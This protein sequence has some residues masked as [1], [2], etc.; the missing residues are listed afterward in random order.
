MAR[1]A[2]NPAT[3]TGQLDQ[4]LARSAIEKLKRR[5]TPTTQ[6]QRAL[7][8]LESEREE[9]LR[10]QYYATIPQKHWRQMSGR[11][12]KVINE[13]AQL[14]GIPF[15]GAVVNLPDVVRTLHDLLADKG[16][17][18]L[19]KDDDML[20]GESNSPAL[21]RYREEKA[22][23]ARLDRLEREQQLIRR[24]VVREGTG[25]IAARLRTAGET[26]ER[27]YG[28]GALEILLEALADVERD[29]E[30]SYSNGSNGHLDVQRSG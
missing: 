22:L 15:G 29:I 3:A 10:W 21:E 28:R 20:L 8:R 6:E 27:Q 17:R 26:L 23:L 1:N 12:A 16:R 11:Q 9:R 14:Y 19:R 24:D 30:R 18:L 4:D 25:R 13:Q 5:E 7:N 2:N